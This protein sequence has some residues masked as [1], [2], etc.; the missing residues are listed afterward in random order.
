MTDR[1]AVAEPP[2][3][4]APAKPKER[5]RKSPAPDRSAPKPKKQPPVAVVVENDD[6]HTFAYVIEV[7]MRV[8]R[9]TPEQAWLLTN[10]IHHRGRAVVWTG[11]L[12]VAELKRD[13][14]RGFGPD[15]YASQAVTFPLG[16][17]LEPLPD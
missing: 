8:C 16:V 10:Q 14:I 3:A 15:F 4:V 2:V 9:H 5:E 13:Q 1:A 7:L 12:E 11:Q 6:H 17:R